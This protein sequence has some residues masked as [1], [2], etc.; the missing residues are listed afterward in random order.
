MAEE[1]ARMQGSGEYGTVSRGVD[2]W[3]NE[4]HVEVF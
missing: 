3:A 2:Y 1:L 4:G